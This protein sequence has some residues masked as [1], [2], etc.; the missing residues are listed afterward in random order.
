MLVA[1]STIMIRQLPEGAPPTFAAAAQMNCSA[2]S[3]AG[4][5]HRC[6]LHSGSLMRG[7][8]SIGDP[9]GGCIQEANSTEPLQHS[10]MTKCLVYLCNASHPIM[11]TSTRTGAACNFRF[12]PSPA[13]KRAGNKLL[14]ERTE[15]F[16]PLLALKKPPS[17]FQLKL[18]LLGFPTRR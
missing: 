8:H 10:A 3:P 2:G 5:R 14:R 16:K 7:A 15:G 11:S 4:S 1:D 12:L 9:D 18:N 13:V 17:V 6:H